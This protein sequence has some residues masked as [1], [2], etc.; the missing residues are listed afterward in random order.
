MLMTLVSVAAVPADAPV[1]TLREWKGSV[2]DESLLSDA[3]GFIA[4]AE[5]LQKLWSRWSVPGPVPQIDFK[6]DIVVL[7]TSRGSGLRLIARRDGEG[8]LKVN[9][10]GTMDFR[11]GFRYV[12][13]VV[14]RTGVKSVNGQAISSGTAVVTG[15]ALLR[16][17]KTDCPKNS[18]NFVGRTR[19]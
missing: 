17:G 13:G 16:N 19:P 7:V 4:S 15:T 11:P 6:K 10:L 18:Q 1:K 3:P 2:A 5:E 9:G 8:N 14:S 12:L